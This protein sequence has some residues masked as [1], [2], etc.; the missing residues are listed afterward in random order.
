MP[1][2][3]GL[4]FRAPSGGARGTC[5]G[6]TGL[7]LTSAHMRPADTADPRTTVYSGENG[8]EQDCQ[9][10]TANCQRATQVNTYFYFQGS[11]LAG[12][13]QAACVAPPVHGFLVG[14]CEHSTGDR[15]RRPADR[16]N[17]GLRSFLPAGS[18]GGQ[19]PHWAR[20]ETAN[21]ASRTRNGRAAWSNVSAVTTSKNILTAFRRKWSN[22]SP[23]VLPP[24]RWC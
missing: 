12:E 13:E 20:G 3:L 19:Q 22:W 17:A 23:S 21:A 10:M 11:R 9:P 5:L 4:H 24:G 18:G 14:S 6:L 1:R 16:H 7:P 8:G 2:H 15:G